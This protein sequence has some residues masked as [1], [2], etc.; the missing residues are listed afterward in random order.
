ML[1]KYSIDV[2]V[3]AFNAEN[4]IERCLNSLLN[5]KYENLRVIIIDDGSNDNTNSIV[6]EICKKSNGKVLLV[7]QQN[8][9]VSVARNKGLEISNADFIGFVD[10]DDYVSEDM[11][12]EMIKVVDDETDLVTC[13]YFKV[14]ED[15]NKIPV[16]QNQKYNNTNIYRDN[17]LLISVTNYV[18][19]KLFRNEIIK[20]SD[21][22][23]PV[24]YGF[25]ED[26]VFL[27]KFQMYS[28]KHKSI[29]KAFYYYGI[30]SSGATTSK[31]SNK[32]LDIPKSLELINQLF[33]EKEI[34]LDFQN[35]L[36]KNSLGYYLR[37]MRDISRFTNKSMQLKYVKAHVEFMDNYF[38]DWKKS[39]KGLKGIVYTNSFL[40]TIY[41][42]TPN[43]IKNYLK[44]IF[45]YMKKVILKFLKFGQTLVVENWILLDSIFRRGDYRNNFLDKFYYWANK[46]SN[47]FKK[48]YNLFLSSY[49]RIKKDKIKIEENL[50]FLDSFWGR[51]IGCNPYAIYREILK[52]SSIDWKFI[53]VKN[54]GI[55]IPK[56]V[57]E[58]QNVFYVE[59]N[60]LNYVIGLAKAKY[61]VT[62]VTF[63]PF[64]VKKREQIFINP[65][66]GIPLKT[67]GVGT[68]EPLK[69]LINTQRMFNQSTLIPMSNRY[70]IEEIVKKHLSGYE[71]NFLQVF[72]SPRVDLTL[73]ANIN[74][75]KK[76]LNLENK[77]VYLYAPTWRGFN[78]SISKDI[79]LQLEAIENILNN[80]Q[81]NDILYVSLH[82]YTKNALDILPQNIKYVPDDIDINE[83]LSI[84]DVLIS[85]YSS[86]FIDYLILDRP[87]I[88]YVPDLENYVEQRGLLFDIKELPVNIANNISELN[89]ILFEVKKPSTFSNYHKYKELWLL[90]E[91]G[92]ASSR[93]WQMAKQELI[94]QKDS[95]KDILI[96]L[97]V[98][99]FDK[100]LEKIENIDKSKYNVWIITYVHRIRKNSKEEE[101]IL[102][103]SKHSNIIFMNSPTKRLFFEQIA[104][105]LIIRFPKLK[106]SFFI[107]II[108]NYLKNEMTKYLSYQEFDFFIDFST[109]KRFALFTDF[110]KATE[111]I[112]IS[113]INKN[114]SSEFKT[115]LEYFDKLTTEQF[116]NKL[117][118]SEK[119]V[120]VDIGANPISVPP[121]DILNKMGLCKIVGFEPQPQAYKNLKNRNPEKEVYFPYAIGKTGTTN[122]NIYKE[123]GFTST[124]KIDE[125]TIKFINNPRWYD[126]TRLTETISMDCLSLDCVPNLPKFDLLKI[127][128][129]CGELNVFE[130]AKQVLKSAICVIPEV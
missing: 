49:F 44:T 74:E 12:L 76:N 120:V 111:K 128:I 97:E 17:N 113:S 77:K 5:Q 75:I 99:Q 70:S 16:I 53:W 42:F 50:V 10:A 73:N 21:S 123:S 88:L 80:L 30:L 103:L 121:Y 114:I 68:K 96:Y 55:G 9:G 48:T 3:P 125:N 32:W 15:K 25:A 45:K 119:I 28:R 23:F 85:D 117:N 124:Y 82:N 29:P 118:F 18:W 4:T 95:K 47:Y 69:N 19:D 38:P 129:Q 102:E 90:N 63:K 87:I 94:M 91:D 100:V 57:L 109:N 41:I 34:F 93:T 7:T 37:R 106:N 24:G 39:I 98:N 65:W 107:N 31:C 101:T 130:D 11:Y 122:L 105:S 126:G 27:Y 60:S 72:G 71:E 14:Y 59:H 127:D 108:E 66:H 112:I 61:L 92:K 79:E 36:M 84:V 8:A 2:I 52:D 62:N 54:N 1:K 116:I 22:I 26:A 20:K 13:G 46:K 86:I 83:F 64:F 33:I 58:N 67:L 35:Q 78:N 6:S 56:D 89:D 115:I 51:K 43:K 81:E 110:I 40:R 104:Y